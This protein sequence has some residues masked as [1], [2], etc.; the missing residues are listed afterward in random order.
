MGLLML[1][2]LVGSAVTLWASWAAVTTRPRPQDVGLRAS[3]DD[4]EHWR[5]H[6]K[7]QADHF[8]V[9]L[10]DI[11]YDIGGPECR[12]AEMAVA[13][14]AALDTAPLPFGAELEES[15]S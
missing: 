11:G 8:R 12:R 6:H 3:L 10:W 9:A 4:A 7:A 5:K 15:S 13:A 14:R 2:M 1:G